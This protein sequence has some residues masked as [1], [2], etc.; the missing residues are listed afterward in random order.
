ME[1]SFST[2]M[3]GFDYNDL[4]LSECT[5][6]ELLDMY[7]VVSNAHEEITHELEKRAWNGK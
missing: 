3:I 4:D 5:K 2:G 6:Q 7:G 1:L